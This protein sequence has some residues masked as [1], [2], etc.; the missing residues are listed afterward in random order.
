MRTV[1]TAANINDNDAPSNF[2]DVERMV[3]FITDAL[4]IY[5]S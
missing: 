2:G 3:S 4:V 5:R 1:T